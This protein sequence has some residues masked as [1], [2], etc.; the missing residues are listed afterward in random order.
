M[1]KLS[2]SFKGST[3]VYVCRVPLLQAEAKDKLEAEDETGGE[4]DAVATAEEEREIFT[5]ELLEAADVTDVFKRVVLV[6]VS[7]GAEAID[8]LNES[9]IRLLS[10]IAV[11][12]GMSMVWV[13][14]PNFKRKRFF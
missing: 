4:T 12:G 2:G 8:S 10:F 11:V 13:S 14:L 7:K 5:M 9:S 6:D 1:D 3:S